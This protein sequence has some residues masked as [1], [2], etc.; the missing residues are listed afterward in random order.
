MPK[1]ITLIFSNTQN[2]NSNIFK[3]GELEIKGHGGLCHNV[4]GYLV[5]LIN[6]AKKLNLMAV[7]PPPWISLS[8]NHND[9][10]QLS[11]D[12]YWD[13]YF[14]LTKI[15]NLAQKNTF[16]YDN[17]GNI[18][19]DLSISYY[20]SKINLNNIKTDADI[21]ALVNYD[22]PKIKNRYIHTMLGSSK[23]IALNISNKYKKHVDKIISELNISEF[24][25][26]HIRRGDMLYYK[27]DLYTKITTSEFVANAIK[28]ININIPIFILT[29]EKDVSYKETL[30][31]LLTDYKLIFETDLYKFLS[32]D[33]IDNNYSMYII[34]CEIAN[35][36]KINV[37]TEGYVRLGKKYDFRLADFK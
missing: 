24:A 19:T 27:K 30:V 15:T 11:K 34:I 9:Q 13:E 28:K 7:L 33:I 37:G 20:D 1:Y 25:T 26:I 8:K 14:D 22:N 29:N 18:I 5:P 21:I 36:A 12:L 6:K 32:D 4:N 31:E 23:S 2:F 3:P 35:R 16:Q 17:N 10:K